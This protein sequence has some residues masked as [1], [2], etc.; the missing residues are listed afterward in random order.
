M[1][2]FTKEDYANLLALLESGVYKGL[3]SAEAAVSL[4]RKLQSKLKE[5]AEDNGDDVS[6]RSK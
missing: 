4:K 2:D 3:A 1:S 6:R 5:I